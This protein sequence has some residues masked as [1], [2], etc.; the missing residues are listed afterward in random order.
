MADLYYPQPIFAINGATAA[1][2]PPTYNSGLGWGLVPDSWKGSGVEEFD[3]HAYSDSSNAVTAAKLV[4]GR[5]EAVTLADD[6][7]ESIASN[8][9]TLTSHAFITGDGPVRFTT[10]GTLPTG[11]VAGTNYWIVKTGANTLKVSESFAAAMSNV[12]LLVSGGSGTHTIVD[13]QTG[14]YDLRTKRVHWAS[15]GW[16]GESNDGSFTLTSAMS[17]VARAKHSQDVVVYSL[18]ATF[19][20]A[21]ATYIR[22]IP[23]P[24]VR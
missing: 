2:T 17:Y 5:R 19:G 18:V 12:T 14:H 22:L 13:V 3:V 8:E 24:V 21:V 15:M 9:L 4:Q 23:Q 20:S 1:A 16:L 11:L 6:D 7:V 10:S